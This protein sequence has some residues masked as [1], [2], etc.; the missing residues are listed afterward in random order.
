MLRF[1]SRGT[2]SDAGTSEGEFGEGESER[3]DVAAAIEFC[4]AAGLPRLW[5]VGWSFGAELALKWGNVP[6]VEGAVLISPALHRAGDGDL[7]RWAASGRPL[8]VLG[9]C[10]STYLRPDE[11][12]ARFAR[13][14]QAHLVVG[15]RPRHLSG[16]GA[17][18]PYR[19]R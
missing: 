7:D 9:P 10:S 15:E 18:R 13:V 8:L 5:L 11:A 14:P 19:A 1:N 3:D 6:A 16:R 17:L 4:Q 12:R 2:G